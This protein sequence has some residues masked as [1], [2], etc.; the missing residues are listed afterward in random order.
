M[1]VYSVLHLQSCVVVHVNELVGVALSFTGREKQEKKK[2]LESF[3]SLSSLFAFV[4]ERE[5]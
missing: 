1:I 2:S 4:V 3:L 5:E